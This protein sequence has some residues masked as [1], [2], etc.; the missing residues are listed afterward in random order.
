MISELP[1]PRTLRIGL[2]KKRR[3]KQ[4]ALT[5]MSTL[6]AA[7]ISV[8]MFIGTA[9][10]AP[11]DEPYKPYTEYASP[12]IQ[13]GILLGKTYVALISQASSDPSIVHTKDWQIA[14]TDL[15]K[16]MDHIVWELGHM[17]PSTEAER[18]HQK[19][20]LKAYAL[21]AGGM[22]R[23]R[24]GMMLQ[25]ED[26]ILKGESLIEEANTIIDMMDTKIPY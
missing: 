19:N 8:L 1:Q 16:E 15:I 24:N 25:N 9:E 18:I 5:L 20:S 11:S 10:P 26:L 13:D 6:V 3:K 17:V 21:Y 22:E 12:A 2:R 4:K 14:T 23:V 7:I